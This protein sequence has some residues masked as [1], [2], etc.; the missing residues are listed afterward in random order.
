MG[1]M[2]EEQETHVNFNRDDERA[3]IYTSDTTTMTK[4]NKL[5]KL[6]GT[7]WKLES[8]ARAKSG[9]EIGRTYSCP[10]EFIS[11]RSKKVKIELSEDEKKKRSERMRLRRDLSS[12]I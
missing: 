2:I 11:F 12:V 9:E 1:L 4:L 3:V 10:K 6:Q 7:E 5:L 8:V